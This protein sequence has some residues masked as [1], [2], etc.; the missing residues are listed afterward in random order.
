MGA[1]IGSWETECGSYG[2]LHH[3]NK[4]KINF[5]LLL[6]QGTNHVSGGFWSLGFQTWG[7]GASC[8]CRVC[9]DDLSRKFCSWMR[10]FL[11]QCDPE[12]LNIKFYHKRI[13]KMCLC[14]TDT[15]LQGWM[16]WT[17]WKEEF[18]GGSAV[19]HW[20][21]WCLAAWKGAAWMVFLDGRWWAPQI[22]GFPVEKPTDL[23]IGEEKTNHVL[24]TQWRRCKIRQVA[25]QISINGPE[26]LFAFMKSV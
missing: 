12:L 11:Q 3:W 15:I 23:K 13:P 8:K 14:F 6:V 5:C 25:K 10:K 1:V 4:T 22:E 2:L 20:Q 17:F 26:C 24:V 16:R 21:E 18:A 9:E 19:F 7:S